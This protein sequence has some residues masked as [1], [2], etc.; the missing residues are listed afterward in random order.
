LVT[1]VDSSLTLLLVLAN[2]QKDPYPFWMGVFCLDKEISRLLERDI[3]KGNHEYSGEIF[4]NIIA[5]C[6]I[7]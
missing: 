7:D 3:K 5:I 4:F 6:M 2:E 1:D